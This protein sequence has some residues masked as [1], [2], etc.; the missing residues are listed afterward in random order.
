[1]SDTREINS[2]T[3]AFN[4]AIA[5]IA[6]SVASP[7]TL[8]KEATVK[9]IVDEGLG[10]YKIQ[11][12]E[13]IF[14][15]TA[16][17][18]EISYNI[19]DNVYFLIPDG[20]FSKNKL[21][22]SP[23]NKNQSTFA[24]AVNSNI[25]I[26]LGDDILEIENQ[27]EI[28]L[29]SYKTI[30]VT[31][32]YDL[33]SL[34][35]KLNYNLE[36]SRTFA[37]KCLVK[38]AIPQEQRKH[39]N[40]GII[41]SIPIVQEGVESNYLVTLDINTLHGDPYN[42]S[43]YT[44]Q[45][46][47]FTI[48]DNATLD[49]KSSSIS[50]F[51]NDFIIQDNT[52]PDDIWIK[53]IQLVSCL[54]ISQ[55]NMNG[56]YVHIG[57][58]NGNTFYGN[59]IGETKTLGVTVYLNGKV[60]N[61]SN[62]DCYWFREN[63][64]ITTGKDGYN[65]FGGIG[66][67]ILN[68]KTKTSTEAGGSESFRYITN[69]YTYDIIG[70]MF[71]TDTT[72]KCVLVKGT[73][74]IQNT[75]TIKIAEPPIELYLFSDRVNN[76]YIENLGEAILTIRCIDTRK[77]V[78]GNTFT[79]VW[80]RFNRLGEYISDAALNIP[81]IA[82]LV[83]TDDDGNNIYEGSIHLDIKDIDQRNHI[84][85]SVINN[86]VRNNAPV[87][88]LIG[89]RSINIL[90]TPE[91]PFYIN[92]DHGDMLFK[93][94]ADGDSPLVANYDGPLSSALKAITPISITLSKTDGTLF[95]AA[96]YA[97]TT[98]TWMVP[99]NSMILLNSSLKTDS[100]SNPGYWT[101]KGSYNT[102]NSLSYSI[103]DVYN[104]NKLDNNIFVSAE[105][106]KS[107][108]T[109]VCN[110]RFL[111]DGAAG[112]NGSKYSGILKYNGVAY[113]EKDSNGIENKLQ[114]IFVNDRS[115]WYTYNP[116]IGV[117]KPVPADET[118]VIGEIEAEL[119]VDGQPV[120]NPIIEWDF[121]D[122]EYNYGVITNPLKVNR[123]GQLTIIKGTKWTEQSHTFLSVV[124]AKITAN[125][126]GSESLTGS[127]EYVYAYYPVETIYVHKFNYLKSMIPEIAGGF[128]QVIFASDGT[129]PKYDSSTPFEIANNLHNT[130]MSNLYNYSWTSSK[131]LVPTVDPNDSSSC[132]VKPVTKYDNG[133]SKNYL[134]VS[135]VPTEGSDIRLNNKI[136]E[137]NKRIQKQETELSYYIMLQEASSIFDE[138]D[139]EDWVADIND[140]QDMFLLKTNLLKSTQ[141]LKNKLYTAIEQLNK[142]K[143]GSQEILDLFDRAVSLYG[144]LESLEI[145]CMN[146]GVEAGAAAAIQGTLPSSLTLSKISINEGIYNAIN[147]T[148]DVYNSS[149]SVYA[150]YHNQ[151]DADFINKVSD[152]ENFTNN[153]LT[154]FVNDDRW[155]IL[156]SSYLS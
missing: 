92:L 147:M 99:I 155:E 131:N 37:L 35:R 144:I 30:P 42:Y 14:D 8:V 47:Y 34:Y 39:G 126:S 5:T 63:A 48:P 104:K 71:L 25:Y 94:D 119:Y 60:T 23:A 142:Y 82:E 106:R 140:L 44:E 134:R 124:Q 50:Y 79:C 68:D 123:Y 16:I 41:L 107:S 91:A 111:K 56:Y 93:Y 17:N 15:A 13:N 59:Y 139:F 27:Q 24:S 3:S 90:T 150:S 58:S 133:V 87:E 28:S 149:I 75:V 132:S 138:F 70:N 130:D 148:I 67:E 83:G 26:P 43:I 151:I 152:M 10:I 57:A 62:F 53:D 78:S 73:E 135:M 154:P 115:Q 85:C 129:N 55:D 89:T 66:W 33:G 112:T 101:I 127:E 77:Q 54:E 72:Y 81:V 105:F 118:T 146:L 145:N 128:D 120:D 97:A 18:S 125:K 9:E 110:I 38:T 76:T 102:N 116:A 52:K 32:A 20:D 51:V 7:G 4:S 49:T 40:Y 11:Y 98:V 113:G 122:G 80:Q 2:L 103:A 19:D 108:A 136:Q 96:E 31:I 109:Q 84:K 22:L 86:F 143:G 137:L 61:V 100:A 1:M 141:E 117:L 36:D 69:K 45:L 6:E 29:C 153:I 156:R 64:S 95:N 74:V 114:L 21:I 121:F 46:L 88:Q 65:Q 12:M